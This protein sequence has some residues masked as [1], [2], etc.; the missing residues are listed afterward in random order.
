MPSVKGFAEGDWALEDADYVIMG[1][2]FDSTTSYRPG[3]RFAPG[4]IRK[5][6][7]NFETYNRRADVDLKNVPIADLGDLEEYGEAVSMVDDLEELLSPIVAEGKTPVLMGGEHSL[8]TGAV[9]AVKPDVYIV[10]DAHLDYR[11]EY[12]G[13]PHSHAC[14]SRRV[15]DVIGPSN[16]FPIGVRSFEKKEFDDAVSHKLE[17]FEAD[18]VRDT[19]AAGLAKRIIGSHERAYLSIDM[20]GMD[21]AYAPGVGTP[22]PFGLDPLWVRDLIRGLSGSIV[23]MDVVEVCPPY[24]NGNTSALAARLIREFLAFSWASSH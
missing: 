20:D 4:E 13:N 3:A 22:E 5:A 24:D 23:G 18:Q 7:Y 14:S 19:D 1:V 17:W 12:L 10:I 21:P 15:A 11:N 9:K 6:S 16:V 2:P 8:T